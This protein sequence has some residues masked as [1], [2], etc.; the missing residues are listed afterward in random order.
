MNA[1]NIVESLR[2]TSKFLYGVQLYSY[3]LRLTIHH[4]SYLSI[5]A[6]F[7]IEQGTHND[8]DTAQG[9]QKKLKG[10]LTTY[11]Y[12]LPDPLNPNRKSIWFTAGTIEPADGASLESWKELFGEK[13]SSDSARTQYT[14]KAR[15]L[16]SEILLGA[17][18]EPMDEHGTASFYLTHPIGGH[19]YAYCDVVF[20][21]RDIR[22][23][24]GHSGSVLVFRRVFL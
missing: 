11:G 7:T 15:S 10:L 21:D 6:S 24:R 4:S 13:H 3:K 1:R 17:V 16:A 18:Q 12:T 23:M 9:K 19:G 22:I 8:D 14:E 2:H 20:M 5:I